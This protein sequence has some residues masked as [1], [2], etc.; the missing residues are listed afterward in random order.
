[1]FAFAAPH[2]PRRSLS[3]ASLTA[4]E[5]P[6]GGTR[7][8]RG[9]DT[10]TGI[11]DGV[12]VYTAEFRC[13]NGPA[14]PCSD[15]Q[16]ARDARP[17]AQRPIP[18]A[19]RTGAN[20]RGG[21]VPGETRH[22]P[23]KGTHA[24]TSQSAQRYSRHPRHAGRVSQWPCRPSQQQPRSAPAKTPES[25][26]LSQQS[27]LG[28]RSARSGSAWTGLLT[29]RYV[30]SGSWWPLSPMPWLCSAGVATQTGD[31]HQCC[32]P[33]YPS[34]RSRRSRSLGSAAPGAPR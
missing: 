28:V 21:R 24:S 3:H 11:F 30:D 5:Q 31:R 16:G 25:V 27:H 19:R 8:H 23:T 33:S 15:S 14:R 29:R 6:A 20:C 32:R 9:R 4:S 1:M 13:R 17:G 10:V 26:T 2:L 34:A 18:Q 7:G 12:R 22:R